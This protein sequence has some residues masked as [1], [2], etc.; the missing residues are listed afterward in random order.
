MHFGITPIF[1][2]A[3]SDGNIS[4]SAIKNAISP[5]TKAVVVTHMWGMPCK[6]KEIVEAL[7]GHSK[8]LLFEDCSHAHGSSIDGKYIGTFG[9]GA[10]WS[11]QGQKLVSGGEGGISL[12]RHPEFHRR[13]LL[14]GHYNKRCSTEIPESHSLYRFRLTGAGLKNRAHPLAVAIAMNQLSKLPSFS[15]T[16]AKFAQRL[17]KG[18]D[19]IAFLN[20]PNVGQ[21][22]RN[23]VKPSWYAFV[24]LFNR[25]EAPPGLTREIFVR[26]LQDTGLSEVDIPNSTRP[27][28]NEPLFTNPADL[29]P[30]LYSST[31][32]LD[33]NRSKVFKN[34]AAFYDQAIKLPVWAFEDDS[35]LVK[36]Y[37][38]TFKMV[39]GRFYR[40]AKL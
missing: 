6:M 23:S 30:H 34:A 39:A 9:D 27:L 16:K 36:R 29:L 10:V 12:T 7:E 26:C 28:S 33:R 2:D 5:R 15:R 40:T 35:E 13:M 25:D 17:A 19:T 3:D 18:L 21:L 14:W 8:I 37:I 32:Y 31:S 20:V 22:Q 24:V 4:S 1:C 11:L 38:E